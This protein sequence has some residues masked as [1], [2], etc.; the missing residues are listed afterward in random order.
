MIASP[1]Q[2]KDN[3]LSSSHSCCNKHLIEIPVR[4]DDAPLAQFVVAFNGASWT[5]PVILDPTSR[6]RLNFLPLAVETMEPSPESLINE[7]P[8]RKP[9]PGMWGIMKSYYFTQRNCE[10]QINFDV[11][12]LKSDVSSPRD[13]LMQEAVYFACTVAMGRLGNYNSSPLYP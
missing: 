10:L 12:K 13:N 7:D 11:K 1:E 8:F 6:Q 2:R 9:Q 4:D 5:D 3:I